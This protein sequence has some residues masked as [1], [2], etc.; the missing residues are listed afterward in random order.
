MYSVILNRHPPTRGIDEPGGTMG[1]SL[2]WD[3]LSYPLLQMAGILF[4]AT[5]DRVDNISDVGLCKRTSLSF[6]SVLS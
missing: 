6:T 2:E 4:V 1:G 3:G 5:V